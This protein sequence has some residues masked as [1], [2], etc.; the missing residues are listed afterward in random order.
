[1]DQRTISGKRVLLTGASGFIGAH[2]TR[3][4]LTAGHQVVACVRDPERASQCMPRARAIAADFGRDH[5]VSDWLPRLDAIDCVINAVGIIRETPQQKFDALHTRAPQALFAACAQTGIARIIQ[6]SA[7]GADAHAK[8][9][10]HLSKKA[11]DDFLRTLDVNWV[12][13]QPSLA[14]GTGGASASLFNSLAAAPV[15]ALIGRGQQRVQPIHIDDLCELIVRLV[16][17]QTVCHETIAAV[18]ARPT[19]MR[20]WLNVLRRGMRLPD[21]LNVPLPMP[22][23]RMLATLGESISSAPLTRETLSM[24]ERGNTGDAT[25]ITK[26][27]GRP[28]LAIEHLI[29]CD[30]ARGLA[31]AARLSLALPLLRWSIAL[32]WLISGVV[33][34]GL[35]PVEQSYALLA[36]SGIT[37]AWAPL[38]LYGAAALDIVFGLLIL[39]GRTPRWLWAAQ[40]ALI[41]GYSMIVALFLPEFWLHPYA[42]MV[43]NLPIAA[44]IFLLLLLEPKKR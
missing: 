38:A 6:I 24:L 8:S 18:G 42:P 28:P 14:Y 31:N 12:I 23:M 15:I 41:A 4:L 22:L 11:A 9:H 30:Q 2:L 17:D 27:L 29:R 40:L 35:F 44:A 1:M 19:T 36:R 20:E 10:Y 21:T 26:I 13:V 43:K 37:G 25:S 34:L 39:A 3:A 7:L 32:L 5:E 33:S 16:S